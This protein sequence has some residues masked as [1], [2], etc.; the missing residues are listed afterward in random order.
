ML[1]QQDRETLC[2]LLTELITAQDDVTH[3]NEKGRGFETE[4]KCAIV[5][6]NGIR[7]RIVAFVDARVEGK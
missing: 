6:R 2:R 4:A 3:W 1:N 5:V 7:H